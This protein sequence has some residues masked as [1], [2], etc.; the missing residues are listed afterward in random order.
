MTT[1]CL[2][3][4]RLAEFGLDNQQIASICEDTSSHY[5][6]P[7]KHQ[8]NHIQK[9]RASDPAYVE[10]RLKQS[11]EH[12]RWRYNNEPEYREH[13]LTKRRDRAAKLKTKSSA[14]GYKEK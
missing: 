9:K 13:V 6:D 8:K 14:S 1:I 4:K 2:T 12:R 7:Y 11:R 3:P 5:T 10:T